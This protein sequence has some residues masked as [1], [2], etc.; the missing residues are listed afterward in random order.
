MERTDKLTKLVMALLFVA[1]LAYIGVYIFR[2]VSDSVV[3]APAVN[4]TLQESVTA[5]G[6]VI[7]DET[8][9]ETDETHVSVTVGDGQRVS[10]NAPMAI[11]M[12]SEAA[13]ERVNRIHELELEIQRISTM[14]SGLD[15][16][17][18]LSTRDEAIRSAV[19]SLTSATA[20]QDLSGLDSSSLQL[21]SLLFESSGQE[22]AT[23]A[24]LQALQFEL[25][26]LK[27]SSGTDT[28]E[29]P[30]PAAGLYSSILD[31]YEHVGPDSVSLLNAAGIRGLIDDRQ[32]VP[33]TAIGKLVTSYTWYFAAI[34]AEEDAA[35]LADVRYAQLDFGR[36]Y[37]KPLSVKI[38]RIS[39]A[40]E[41]ECAVVFSCDDAMA[42]TL[43]MRQ[44][45]AEIIIRE[46][47]GIRVP[48]QAMHLDDETGQ[49][50]V[51]TVTAMQAERKDVE[52]V[53][54]AEDYCLVQPAASSGGSLR[55]GNEIIVSADDV[56][57]GKL[58][59]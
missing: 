48:V 53:Y 47:T 11:S 42:E 40:E 1:L 18:D 12:S 20:R 6:I 37:S 57:E 31:G 49:A 17:Q 10:A 25:N 52:V 41:G 24:D 7:R 4:V 39:P 38:V 34:M 13:L 50:Y 58:M 43:A 30:A 46:Y 55:E 8:L 14:L 35:P 27:S 28:A 3:T 54:T 9:I 36:Y 19:L 21:R 23:E 51:Y 59:G 29:I 33:E 56:Y 5:S 44:V 15:T 2:G 45:T 32:E 26:G 22:A 16:A